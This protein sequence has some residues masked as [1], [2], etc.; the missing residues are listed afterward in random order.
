MKHEFQAY[1]LF[2][3]NRI[4]ED[5]SPKSILELGTGSSTPVFSEYVKK[6]DD[7]HLTA[8]DE[9]EQ[10]LENSISLADVGKNDKR[11]KFILSK[12]V[13]N[14]DK[15]PWESKYDV[16]LDDSYE[17]VFIDGP[18]LAYDGKKNKNAV[19]SNIFDLAF[20]QI[21]IV[22]IRKA[23]VN[24]IKKRMKN[25]YDC[26]HSDVIFGQINEDYNYFTE[27]YLKDNGKK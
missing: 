19:N 2:S 14:K 22:D 1:K 7:R 13:F 18:S 3:L 15:E 23:T 21:I 17:L 11:F 20:P 10:W 26:I 27:F 9:N 5:Y 16:K 24:E 6:T 4:L 8:I 12:K 25:Y